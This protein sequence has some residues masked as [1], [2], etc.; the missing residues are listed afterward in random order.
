MRKGLIYICMLAV[1]I[2][3]SA[4]EQAL[5]INE[6]KTR[7]LEYSQQ[8]KQSAEQ[9]KA[10]L[11]A[12]KAAKTAF[13]PQIDF[14]GNYQY[15]IN[16]Y[17]MG[18]GGTSM[19]ME[20]DS[21]ELQAGVVQP[22]YSGG[23]IYNSYKAAQI[24]NEIAKQS[25]T[26]TVDNVLYSADVS[27]WSASAQK[28]MYDIMCQYV[29]IIGQFANILTERFDEGAISKTDLLQVQARL[30]E[31]ELQKISAYKSYR[32]ALQN[33]NILMGN[34]PV[35][36]IVISDSIMT[37]LAMPLQ[38]GETEAMVN[39]PEYHISNL[40]IDYQKRQVNLAKSK[41]NPNFS[42]GFKETWGTQMLNLT[43]STM[44]NSV[45]YA[46]V[47]VPIF[48]WGARFREVNSQKAVLRSQEYALQITKDQITQEISK[49]WTNLTEN[50]KQVTLAKSTIEIAEENL[51]LNTFSYTEG[52]LPI[53]DVLSAQLTW[54]QSYSNLIQS[55]LQQ[56]VS[57]A[58]YYKAIGSRK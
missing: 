45:V 42:V 54:I 24:K 43:G 16:N 19:A 2:S 29:D 56:K 33:L 51:E 34:P 38:I 27:Y 35:E 7:V 39:R 49:A 55:W 9:R 57:L 6:Y 52:K 20:H 53:L 23:N 47:S 17:D 22:V 48:H 40:N 37:Y 26:L 10:M 30:K 50:T 58:D 5:T 3:V 28:E 41:Y 12:V 11:Q 1:A 32:I 36:E 44:F 46:S 4:Q 15:R 13:F 14:S 31:A 21:Y 18:F 25:E 8:I